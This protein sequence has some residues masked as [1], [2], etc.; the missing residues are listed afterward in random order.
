MIVYASELSA[1][2]IEMQVTLSSTS[3]ILGG[4][5][6]IGM[7]VLNF[8]LGKALWKLKAWARIVSIFLAVLGLLYLAYYILLGG[9]GFVSLVFLVINVAIAVYLVFDK[10]AKKIFK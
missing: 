6:L 10:E 5:I 1:A 3:F 4:I 8:F 9:F 7:A 2:F